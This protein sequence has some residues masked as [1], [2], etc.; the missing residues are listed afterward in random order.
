MPRSHLEKVVANLIL[1]NVPVPYYLEHMFVGKHYGTYL[2]EKQEIHI[3]IGEILKL[4][5]ISELLPPTAF[6]YLNSF[7]ND[8]QNKFATPNAKWQKNFI[9]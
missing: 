5:Q 7:R 9:P 8:K 2:C 3:K 4:H 1:S 6:F